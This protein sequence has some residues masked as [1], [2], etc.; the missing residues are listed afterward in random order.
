[1]FML[2]RIRGPRRRGASAVELAFICPVVL[3]LFFALGFGAMGVFRY[4]E[5]AHLAR[6]GARYASTH[7]GFYHSEGIDTRTGVPSISTSD[8]MRTYLLPYCTLLDPNSL[9]VNLSYTAGLTPV[10]YPY[11]SDPDP[12]LVPPGSRII[13]NNVRVTVSYRWMPELYLVGPF[14]LT[15][16][17]EMPMSY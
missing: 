4:Q 7:G 1:M 15:S 2:Q 11:Y 14:T 8:Q 9:T 6:K 10:N 12:N 17:S 3:F 13:R 16:T 5:V